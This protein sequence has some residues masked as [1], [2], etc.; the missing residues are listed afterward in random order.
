VETC[1]VQSLESA[2]RSSS[3]RAV[4]VEMVHK[5]INLADDYLAWEHE[6]FSIRRL[7]AFTV[8]HLSSHKAVQRNTVLDTRSDTTLATQS[9]CVRLIIDT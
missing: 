9:V 6:R 7:P 5:K 3:G 2:G 1:L 4:N 8:S